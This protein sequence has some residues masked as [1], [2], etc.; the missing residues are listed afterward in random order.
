MK[1]ITAVVRPTALESI[2]VALAQAG[3]RGITVTEVEGY[4]RQ[5]GH[6]EVYRGEEYTI[7]FLTKAKVEV[8]CDD[9]EAP[10][11]IRTITE[12]ARTGAVGDGK[13]WM[14]AVEDVIRIRT[15]EHGEAA[16]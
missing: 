16:L 6:T 5:Q 7:D 3:V 10:D 2:E 13:V 15:G 8:L 9:A 1:L 11:V 14:T 12:A 4:G